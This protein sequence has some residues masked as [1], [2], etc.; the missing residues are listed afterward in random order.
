M[1][2]TH[3]SILALHRPVFGIEFDEFDDNISC[4]IDPLLQSDLVTIET[5]LKCRS[6]ASP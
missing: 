3:C 6:D 1:L 4:Q 5:A 2:T